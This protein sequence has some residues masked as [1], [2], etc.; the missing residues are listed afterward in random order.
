MKKER[1]LLGSLLFV[2]L[3]AGL[4]SLP[5]WAKKG[6]AK[7]APPPTWVELGENGAIIARQVLTPSS[8][9]LAPTCPSIQINGVATQMQARGPV[10]ENFLTVCQA[11]I[12][13]GATS[14]SI[15][16][17]QLP[18][19]KATI[20]KIVLIG[21]TGCKGDTTGTGKKV[22]PIEEPDE[23]EE[24]A[25]E[26]APV[27]AASAS[28]DKSK[29]KSKSH[30]KPKSKQDC[31]KKSDWPF[32]TVAKH[33]AD[34][35]PDLVI[36][37][38]DYVYVKGDNW[39]NWTAQFF[40]P[41]HDL[42]LAAPWIFVRGNHE[43][44]S[45]HPGFFYLLDPRSTTTCA[46]NNTPP[47]LVKAGG[48]QFLVMDSSGALCD[49]SPTEPGGCSQPDFTQ[50]INTWTGL[51][52]QAKQLLGSGNAFLLTHRPLWGIK[53]PTGANPSGFCQAPQKKVLVAI[54]STMQ[55]G[56]EKS[57]IT[58]IKMVL[59]GHIHNF[60]L[61]TYQPQNPGVSP[62]PQLVV[63]DSG[64]E[65][66]TPPPS[67]FTSCKLTAQNGSLN[68]STF[69]GMKEFGYGV[70]TSDASKFD[71]YLKKGER[72]LKCDIDPNN[73]TCK[74]QAL[75]VKKAKSAASA[76]SAKSK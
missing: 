74:A 8:T 20:S 28:G 5:A 9:G 75:P 76:G 6:N 11:V 16:S 52:T 33:A 14:A 38:G 36:H 44:C 46:N 15:G 72:A 1:R 65:L 69:Q 32:S 63:G 45:L 73:A 25:E 37:V 13:N 60:Q 53:V 55:A 17:I 59:S 39:E 18:L 26:A 49:F 57:G 30:S 22:T 27:S 64:V 71:L 58:G 12:P 42:L 35:K 62:Q 40:G 29:S 24:A 61:I 34:E 68:L 47:Y 4:I 67:S 7:A 54:N 23:Q 2:L 50:E 48:S 70:L 31:P 3:F 43:I 10:P 41:A 19:P 66:S 51:F 56:Y 21:D